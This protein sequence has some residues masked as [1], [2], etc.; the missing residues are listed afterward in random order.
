MISPK[1]K[2][3]AYFFFLKKIPQEWLLYVFPRTYERILFTIVWHLRFNQGKISF[4]VFL[5]GCQAQKVHF[6]SLVLNFSRFKMEPPS[7]FFSC[8]F[9]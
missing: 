2:F 8:S 4:Q 9:G 7:T 5:G 1:R 6:H 3:P